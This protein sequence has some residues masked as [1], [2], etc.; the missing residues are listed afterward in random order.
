MMYYA[1]TNNYYSSPNLIHI[2]VREN[3]LTQLSYL[4]VRYRDLSLRRLIYI[5]NSLGKK[6]HVSH[7]HA[8]TQHYSRAHGNFFREHPYP[9]PPTSRRRAHPVLF[10]ICHSQSPSLIPT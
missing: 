7:V 5:I 4:P 6:P 2:S 1:F 8:C 9:P 3:I 10:S